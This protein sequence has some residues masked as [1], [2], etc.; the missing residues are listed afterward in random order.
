MNR[1]IQLLTA[2]VSAALVA[3]GAHAQAIDHT[4]ASAGLAEQLAHDPFAPVYIVTSLD[5]YLAGLQTLA[6][7]PST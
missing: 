3:G 5:S 6:S 1:N 4:H 7:A 2:L